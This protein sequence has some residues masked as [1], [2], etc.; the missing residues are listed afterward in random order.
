V[1]LAELS[2]SVEHAKFAKSATATLTE[3]GGFMQE[4]LAVRA[5]HGHGSLSNVTRWEREKA[6]SPLCAYHAH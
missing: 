6:H 5:C 1:L 3:M 4:L 2:P